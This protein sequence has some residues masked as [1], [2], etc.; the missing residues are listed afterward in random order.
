MNR[1]ITLDV[2]DVLLKYDEGFLTHLGISLSDDHTY[3]KYEDIPELENENVHRIIT[4]FNSSPLFSMLEPTDGAVDAINKIKEYGFNINLITACGNTPSIHF[5]RRVNLLDVFGDVFD[6]ITLIPL[7]KSKL[8]FLSN[9]NTEL[10]VD[11]SE[12]HYYSGTSLG[13]NSMLMRTTFNRNRG[14]RIN[15]SDIANS[16]GCVMDRI[17]SLV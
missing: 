3:T 13:I 15:E 6:D 9:S 7:G 17:T 11:D 4:Q 5:L 12:N 10:W 1:T 16:W 8:D 14:H 2:D